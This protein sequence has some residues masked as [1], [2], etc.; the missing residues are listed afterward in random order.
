MQKQK[1]KQIHT[2]AIEDGHLKSLAVW[3]N[4]PHSFSWSVLIACVV[5]LFLFLFLFLYYSFW[6]IF[7]CLRC[8]SVS[9]SVLF[10]KHN[11]SGKQKQKETETDWEHRNRNRNKK[12]WFAHLCSVFVVRSL[13]FEFLAAPQRSSLYM[14]QLSLPFLRAFHSRAPFNLW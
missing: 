2:Q 4:G 14:Y 8:E 13:I 7:D 1:Q 6:A 9:V 5:N 10:L 12:H 11:R 3:I